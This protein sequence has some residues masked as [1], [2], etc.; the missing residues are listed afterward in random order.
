VAAVVIAVIGTERVVII[1]AVA[2]AIYKS[3]YSYSSFYNTNTYQYTHPL[4]LKSYIKVA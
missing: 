1:I 4:K 2:A 3:V